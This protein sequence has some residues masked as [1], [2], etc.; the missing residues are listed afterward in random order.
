MLAA[1]TLVL[2]GVISLLLLPLPILT[3]TAACLPIYILQYY[4]FA[5]LFPLRLILTVLFVSFMST[6]I[7]F[8]FPFPFLLFLLLF[9]N[10]N[11]YSLALLL[12]YFPSL[13][14]FLYNLSYFFNPFNFIARSKPIKINACGSLFPLV[15]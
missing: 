15:T 5:L 7:L 14:F 2:A 10:P 11:L 4:I 13:I 9:S 6:Y 1:P 8:F 3:V 12:I